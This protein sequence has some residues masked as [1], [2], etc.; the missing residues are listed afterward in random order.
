MATVFVPILAPLLKDD[1]VRLA[2]LSAMHKAAAEITKEFGKTT[3]T[4]DEKVKFISGI[5]LRNGETTVTVDTVNQTY[6]WVNDGTPGHPIFPGFFTGK[7]NKKALV[8]GSIFVPKTTPGVIR[9]IAGFR[10]GQ[11]KVVNMVHNQEIKPRHFDQMIAKD[12]QK[13]FEALVDA[14]MIKAAKDSGHGG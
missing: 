8:F 12:Y 10:G 11:Q 1:A 7:S 6:L 9:S 3:A 4:W 5:S 14:A 13:K 2:L